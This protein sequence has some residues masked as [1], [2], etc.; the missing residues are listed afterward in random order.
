MS[1]NRVK[2]IEQIYDHY[3]NEDFS[4]WKLLYE[5]QINS[6]DG[7]VAEEFLKGLEILDFNSQKI[8]DFKKIN[9]K[10][11]I[12]N[13]WGIKTVPNIA[14]PKEF[15]KYLANKKFT[16]TCWLR[17]MEEIDYLEEPDMFH[18]VFAHVPMLTD[19]DYTNFFQNI[20]QLALE[21]IN[22]EE[23][24]KKLQRLY[25]FTIEF[26]LMETSNGNKIYG[27]G[28]ISSKNEMKNAFSNKSI[29]TDFN[30]LEIMNQDFRIDIV[31]EKYFVI[32]S[33]NQLSGSLEDVRHE[34]FKN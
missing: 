7:I 10:L 5:T 32:K 14:Q 33:F 26:G 6:L 11:D 2:P 23:K 9:E 29:K 20:G 3:T 21:V 27:A 24:L 13:G 18:D 25:W 4:V 28:I 22:D 34:L 8:P 12:I 31:Q 1:R 17:S 19:V 16:S 15:F 30:V